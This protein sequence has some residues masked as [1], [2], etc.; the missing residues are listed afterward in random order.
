[1]DKLDEEIRKVQKEAADLK[2][3]ADAKELELK[4]LQRAAALR[5]TVSEVLA[6]EFEPESTEG[7][8]LDDGS[9]GL[10]DVLGVEPPE[11]KRGGRQPGAISKQWRT[12]LNDIL[13]NQPVDIEGIVLLAVRHG[14]ELQHGSA[15]SRMRHYIELGYVED[16]G[17]GRYRV[18]SEAVNRFGLRRRLKG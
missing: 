13:D 17:E 16:A 18:T 12:I 1:M 6:A 11:N 2:R 7:P 14:L 10:E 5:P 15:L 8:P 9:A 4:A 3:R